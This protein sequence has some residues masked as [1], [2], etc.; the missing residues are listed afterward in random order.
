M[1]DFLVL[2]KGDL[3]ALL[4]TNPVLNSRT[5]KVKLDDFFYIHTSYNIVQSVI[6]QMSYEIF[7]FLLCNSQDKMIRANK[8]FQNYIGKL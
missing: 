2:N 4:P 6:W 8:Y 3:L 1:H 5:D 7:K